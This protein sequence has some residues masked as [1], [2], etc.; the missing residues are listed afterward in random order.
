MVKSVKKNSGKKGKK[1][2]T[3]KNNK[4]G[5]SSTP[6]PFSRSALMTGQPPLQSEY[7]VDNKSKWRR[8]LSD[9]TGF[10]TTSG[11]VKKILKD[12]K[13]D[14]DPQK[15][16]NDWSN[17][18]MGKNMP[19]KISDDAYALLQDLMPRW[20]D[21]DEKT[22]DTLKHIEKSTYTDTNQRTTPNAQPVTQPNQTSRTRE[23]ILDDIIKNLNTNKLN[24]I[25]STEQTNLYIA[26]N[27]ATGSIRHDQLESIA[28]YI[29]KKN[30]DNYGGTYIGNIPIFKQFK[31][32]IE[33]Y[34]PAGGKRRTRRRKGKKTRKSNKKSRKTRKR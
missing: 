13:S 24:I 19:I 29:N 1:S 21:Q 10:Y 18:S 23:Q 4:G 8:A 32:N 5:H 25:K 20:R 27:N 31:Q 16:A 14:R 2:G 26:F 17:L 22:Y 3:K 11:K 28:K 33:R 6:I 34:Q 30:I 15:L 9:I 7:E 12:F